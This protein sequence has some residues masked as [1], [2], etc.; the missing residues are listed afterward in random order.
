M[1]QKFG[2]AEKLLPPLR[3]SFLDRANNSMV[4][5]WECKKKKWL[6]KYKLIKTIKNLEKVK[7]IKQ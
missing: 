2:V 1:K 5:H 4:A 6:N 3:A 7:E